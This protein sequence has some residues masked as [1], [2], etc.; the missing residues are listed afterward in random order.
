MSGIIAYYKKANP[1][2]NWRN[3]DSHIGVAL[4]EALADELKMNLV[5]HPI[6]EDPMIP[7]PIDPSGFDIAFCQK[8]E[9]PA[10]RPAPF[11]YS[12]VGDIVH[13]EKMI[14]AWIDKVRPDF[15]GFL[16]S[17]PQWLFEICT[18]R[19]C[20]PRAFRWFEICLPEIPKDKDII[21][22]C[23]GCI[24]R[25]YP[26]RTRIFYYLK[27]KMFPGVYL[28]CGSYGAY[29]LGNED[30]RDILSRSRYYLT[31]PIWDTDVAPKYVEVMSYGCAVITTWCDAM[32]DYG[33]VP[34][35]NIITI[36]DLEEIDEILA[37]DRWK[38]IGEN[39]RKL[40]AEKHMVQNRAKMIS[41]IYRDWRKACNI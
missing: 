33:F 39:A 35:E 37:S 26:S 31:G 11:V 32:S 18:K 17:T 2:S 9:I 10:E 38:I 20:I 16:E 7:Y 13:H 4:P 40:I 6:K 23:S 5:S 25:P 15:V 28:S 30:Y 3:W 41:D 34:G 22:L 8:F 21:G 24:G 27:E 12:F 36:N 19:N 14:E 1:N 29:P